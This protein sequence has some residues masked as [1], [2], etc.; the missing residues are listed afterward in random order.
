MADRSLRGIRLGA[1]SLQSE[2]GVVLHERTQR[3][4]VCTVCNRDSTL[5]FAADAEA[6][7]TWECRYCG[8]EAVLRVGDTTVTV[9]HSDDKAARTHWDML[10]ERRT[11]PELEELLEERL[12]LLRQSRGEKT[13]R[14][15][16]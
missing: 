10:L 2:E 3:T 13:S 9:D 11:I 8:A 1:Q 12:T 16:A 4:Y 5:T 6:P 14:K 15:T 7:D